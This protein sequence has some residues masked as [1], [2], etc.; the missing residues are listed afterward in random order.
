MPL[1]QMKS[2]PCG[3]S[4][5][6]DAHDG[7]IRIPPAKLRLKADRPELSLQRPRFLDSQRQNGIRIHAR[8]H[9]SVYGCRH[10]ADHRIGDFRGR[11]NADGIEQEQRGLAGPGGSHGPFESASA[12]SRRPAS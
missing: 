10:G 7:I 8:T 1:A 12:R 4:C 9:D 2:P 6:C 5:P 11:Q 3:P